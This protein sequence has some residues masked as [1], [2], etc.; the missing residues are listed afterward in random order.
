[1]PAVQRLRGDRP[2]RDGA[3]R[4]HP[5]RGGEARRIHR[6]PL[7]A[8]IAVAEREWGR[9]GPILAEAVNLGVDIVGLSGLI[10][11]SLDEMVFVAGEMERRGFSIPLLIGGATTSRTHTPLKMQ[12]AS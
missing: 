4:P 11:P 8:G 9:L 6:P 10:T 1:R 7:E 5:R 3:G 2:G 12:T